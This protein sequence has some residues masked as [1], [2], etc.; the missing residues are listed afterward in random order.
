M[1]GPQLGVMAQDLEQS[2]MG[3]KMVH[4]DENGVKRVD[5]NNN[6]S[7]MMAALAELNERLNKLEGN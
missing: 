2:E 5:Y 3:S 6:G 1:Q 4:E 7:T